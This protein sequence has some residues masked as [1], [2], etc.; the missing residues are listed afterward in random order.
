MDYLTS[1]YGCVF[2][3]GLMG[4]GC[5]VLMLC[6]GRG[7]R[8]RSPL[9]L[10]LVFADLFVCCLSGPITAARY[11][12][13]TWT[14]PWERLAIFMQEWPVSVST[15][16]M[17][18][19]SVDRYFTVKNYRPARQVV[20][21]RNLLLSAVIFTWVS[22]AAIS[23]LQVFQ[24]I[25]WK[26]V[27]V[28]AK[29]IVVHLIPA[30]VVFASHLGVHAKLT[31]LSLTARAK[32]GELPLPMPL[33]RRPTNVIIVAGISNKPNEPASSK[34]IRK[35]DVDDGDSNDE[36]PMKSTLRSRRKLANALLFMATLFACCWLPHVVC[37]IC[38]ELNVSPTILVQR[39]SLFLGH[40][41][42][43][44]SPI[45]YWILNH[46]WLI[47]PCKI[48]FPAS[49][50]HMASS[51]NEAALGPFNPRFVR[52]PHQARRCSSHYLY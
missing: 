39:Y 47:P 2:F 24:K 15:L 5:L 34:A 7:A 50:R 37:L 23:S 17:M 13:T 25:S 49:N 10:G 45:F 38:T 42:S 26:R 35:K 33:L 8:M 40:A 41:H 29:I 1:F 36:Q 19:L 11:V 16:S 52:P 43:A 20:Q 48:R 9:L 46:R 51:T 32:H 21:R 12:I 22:S 3:M 4:N 44:L 6:C 14:Q 31:A 27:M 30:C 18:A 28:I